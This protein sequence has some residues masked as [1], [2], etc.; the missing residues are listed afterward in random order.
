MTLKLI[1]PVDMPS[2]TGPLEPRQGESMVLLNLIAFKVEHDRYVPSFTFD[3]DALYWSCV[4]PAD[5]CS[6]PKKGIA[7]NSGCPRSAASV[8][9]PVMPLCRLAATGASARVVAPALAAH[10]TSS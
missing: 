10:A 3:A 2:A 4:V 5:Q 1:P 9:M 7:V 8:A 6:R